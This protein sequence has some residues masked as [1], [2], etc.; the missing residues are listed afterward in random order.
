[1]GGGEGCREEAVSSAGR[2]TGLRDSVVSPHLESHP[3]PAVLWRGFSL[4]GRVFV[5]GVAGPQGR[6]GNTGDG[7]SCC[8]WPR[9]GGLPNPRCVGTEPA[10]RA[11]SREFSPPKGCGSLQL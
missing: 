5:V 1:M 2:G 7:L 3:H 8:Q 6:R 10:L 11:P 4:L 9:L